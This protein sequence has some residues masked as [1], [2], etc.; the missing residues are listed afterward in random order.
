MQ[1]IEQWDY[2][3]KNHYYSPPPGT[4]DHHR[5]TLVSV[6]L[7]CSPGSGIPIFPKLP[8]IVR[9]KSL[10]LSRQ[11]QNRFYPLEYIQQKMGLNI[12]CSLNHLFAQLSG[13]YKGGYW[14]YL[15]PPRIQ[16]VNSP[17]RILGVNTPLE[18]WG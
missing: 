9:W 4:V 1:G 6:R 5:L 2:L 15:P 7:T 16:G 17:P 10:F 14:G 8:G 12:P 3:T 18:S 13:G 11:V